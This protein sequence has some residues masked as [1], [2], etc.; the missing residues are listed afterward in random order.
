VSQTNTQ[1]ASATKVFSVNCERLRL[2]MVLN[3][4]D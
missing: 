4:N 1:S 3:V 2:A